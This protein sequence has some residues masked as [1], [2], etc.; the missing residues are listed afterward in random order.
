MLDNLLFGINDVVLMALTTIT[1]VLSST[2]DTVA[3]A[4]NLAIPSAILACIILGEKFD[5]IDFIFATVNGT[6]LVLISKSRIDNS[7]VSQETSV[8]GL[9]LSFGCLFL[10]CLLPIAPRRLAHRGK[11][12]PN[13]LTFMAGSCGLV[14]TSVYLTV[15]NSW[16]LPQTSYEI[17]MCLLLG[18]FTVVSF[19]AYT[20]ALKTECALAVVLG[21]TL[22]IPLTYCYDVIFGNQGIKLLTVAGVCLTVG[23]TICFYVKSYCVTSS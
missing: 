10:C 13:L 1:M 5:T 7:E 17:F 20:R 15:T 4:Y 2:S 3:I 16:M 12:D 9:L 22:C 21:L 8:L 11:E 18:F 19:C 6:G 14:M 23:S